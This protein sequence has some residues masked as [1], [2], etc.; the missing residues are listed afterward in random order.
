[1]L[2]IIPSGATRLFPVLGDPI[3]QV[4]SPAKVTQILANRGRDAIVVPIH[5]SSPDLPKLFDAL[6]AVRNIDG[7]LV[8]VPHKRL[9]FGLC[10]ART[11]R[12]DFVKA[13]NVVRRSVSGWYGDNTDGHGYLEGIERE[14]FFVVG[15][16]AL[17]VGCGGAGSAIALEILKRGAA[18]LAIHDVDAARRDEMVVKLAQSFPGKVS[19]GHADPSGYDLIANATPMGMQIGDPLPVEVR[20][21]QPWQFVACAVTKPEVSPLIAAAQEQG[22]RTMTGLGMFDAQAETLTDFLLG[23][24][25]SRG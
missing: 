6:S 24:E 3:A 23:T 22:C 10:S 5:V 9:A 17:L 21:L 11:D 8:T 13:V 12:A 25:L 19:I 16:R 20:K 7:M 18:E 4:Q 15:R 14:G 2:E 1:M